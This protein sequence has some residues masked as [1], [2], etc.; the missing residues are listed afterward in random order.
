MGIGPTVAADEQECGNK[1]GIM[2]RPIFFL[3]SGGPQGPHEGSGDF[4]NWLRDTLGSEY[5]VIHPTMPKPEAPDYAAWKAKVGKELGKLKDGVIFVGHSLGGAVLLKYLT[6]EPCENPIA[7]MFLVSAPFWGGDENWQY[8]PFTLPKNFAK[9]LPKIP[10]VFLYHSWED[11]IVPF[12]H[13][14]LYSDQLP[15]ATVR[16]LD[17]NEHVFRRGLPRLVEDIKG[18]PVEPQLSP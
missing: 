10:K 14:A 16:A 15:Q 9:N 5:K 7:G 12:A 18:L 8:E 4:V 11:E 3:H 1:Q 17:G 13:L 6:E 2:K